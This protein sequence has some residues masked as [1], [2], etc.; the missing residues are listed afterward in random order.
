[1]TRT[2]AIWLYAIGVV[3]QTVIFGF[4]A[5]RGEIVLRPAEAVIMSVLWPLVFLASKAH[6]A[7]QYFAN[8]RR[9]REEGL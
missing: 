1:M 4:E 6:T 9:R 3:V 8:R 7:G 5:G 2:S